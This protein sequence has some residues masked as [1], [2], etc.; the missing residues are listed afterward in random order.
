MKY[1]TKGLRITLSAAVETEPDLFFRGGLQD[2]VW[3]SRRIG[4]EENRL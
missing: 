2:F 1:C 3:V 4:E